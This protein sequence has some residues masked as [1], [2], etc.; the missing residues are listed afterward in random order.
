MPEQ[1]RKIVRYQLFLSTAH[2]RQHYT[3]SIK[4]SSVPEFN[5]RPMTVSLYDYQISD[6]QLLM[7]TIQSTIVTPS[8]KENKIKKYDMLFVYWWIIVWN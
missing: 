1:Y 6:T 3:T 4:K 5:K 7:F 8:T 2:A